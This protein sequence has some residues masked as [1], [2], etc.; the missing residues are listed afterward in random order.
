MKILLLVLGR[1]EER[2]ELLKSPNVEESMY[3]RVKLLKIRRV[4]ESKC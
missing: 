4:E 2:V 1:V 3:Q